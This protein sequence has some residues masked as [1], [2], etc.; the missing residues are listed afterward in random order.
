M[1]EVSVAGG[2]EGVTEAGLFRGELRTQ[3]ESSN[4]GVRLLSKQV[5]ILMKLIPTVCE[6][7]EEYRSLPHLI[8]GLI[9]IPVVSQYYV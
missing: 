5:D 7:M 1:S 3:L 4:N 2:D 8:P 9:N 6:S